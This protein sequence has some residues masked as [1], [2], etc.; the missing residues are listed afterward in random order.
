MNYGQTS[1]IVLEDGNEVNGIRVNAKKKTAVIRF[2]TAKE[3]D[4][5]HLA[6][7]SKQAKA[8]D[9]DDADLLDDLDLFKKLRLDQGEDFDE[10]EANYIIRNLLAVGVLG[11]SESGEE[12]IVTLRSQFGLHTH[13]LRQPSFKEMTMFERAVQKARVGKGTFAHVHKLYNAL[14]TKTDGYPNTFTDDDIP[15]G[16]KSLCVTEVQN[17][18]YKLDPIQIDPNA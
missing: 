13:T 9:D 12:L 3:Q 2:P 17:A 11:S 16:H 14:M 8:Q 7:Y 5:Y 15:G 18:H 1:S 6:K 4:D 10:F